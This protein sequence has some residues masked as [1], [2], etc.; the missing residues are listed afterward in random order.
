MARI[1]GA[2]E[3]T[4]FLKSLGFPTLA[5]HDTFSHFD[6]TQ[7]GR[8]ILVIGPMGSGKTE[9]AARVWRDAA[10][11]QR[12]GE[13]VRQLT[14][15]GEVDRRK[16]FFIRSEIDGARFVDYPDDALAYRGGYIQCGE[17]IAKIRDSFALEQVIEAN[18]TVGTFIID[19]ASFFDERIAY[20]I[21]NH[22]YERGVMFIF[23]T[24]ILNF[25]RDLFN[26]TARLMLEMATD[27]IPLTAYCEHH[28]CV[29]DAFYT[30]RYYQVDGQECPA[31]YFDPLII[32]GG[33]AT[34]E[35]RLEPNYA[36]RCDEHHY[37]PGK[38]YTFFHLKPLGEKA[39]RGDEGELV[40][41]LAALK[42]DIKRSRLYENFTERFGGK[43]DEEI[44]FNALK[45]DNIAE[46]ALAFLFFEQNL[47]A[48]QMLL[49]LASQLDLDTAYLEKVLSDNKRPVSFAQPFLF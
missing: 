41:E 1:E 30:Y 23:P 2:G 43:K 46:K 13:R 12:K 47:I 48:E 18:P 15:S 4:D 38:E 37:L 22:S 6:F 14:S 20:V 44:L 36:A 27:V 5:V 21:R 11:A 10:V 9:F 17:N 33:D 42:G 19:E 39:S 8:R 35:S 3:A 16:V 31:L 26:S 25:R 29:N 7:P 45:V 32:V 28:D 40:E 34:K 49:R 24:L